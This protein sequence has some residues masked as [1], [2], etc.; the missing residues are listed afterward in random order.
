MP[1]HPLP[2]S[3]Q[4]PS[5]TL[6]TL[7]CCVLFKNSFDTSQSSSGW[8]LSPPPAGECFGN[9]ESKRPRQPGAAERSKQQR[10]VLPRRLACPG[11]GW[12]ACFSYLTSLVSDSPLSG[13]DFFSWKAEH[14]F[15]PSLW[16][17]SHHHCFPGNHSRVV[18]L[19]PCRN[20]FAQKTSTSEPG[21]PARRDL[22]I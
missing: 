21:V 11:P 8:S 15:F 18:D 6:L 4:H 13:Q 10:G 12:D 1:S 5:Q 2:Y 3:E 19:V 7:E 14:L 22:G 9:R 16:C 17:P 20:P